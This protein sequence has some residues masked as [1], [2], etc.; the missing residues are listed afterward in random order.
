MNQPP[1]GQ[2]PYGQ[3]PQGQPNPQGAMPQTGL[4]APAAAQAPNAA[5]ETV[6][7]QGEPALV[8][9]LGALLLAIFTLGIAVL[10]FWFKRGGV[11]YRI[12]NQRVVIDR[13][14]LSKKMEQLD[15]YRVHDFTVERPFGQRIMGTGNL[16]LNTFDKTTP[17]VELSGLKTDVVQ[18][19]ETLRVAVE[20]AK[21]LRGVRMVDYEQ[22]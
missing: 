15:L 7:F 13:G 12:T 21:Q 11:S 2:P 22:T 4:V 5:N 16:R 9:S 6:L 18:L 19:Y 10:F 8:H 20:A 1:Y 14:I 17:V 3:P